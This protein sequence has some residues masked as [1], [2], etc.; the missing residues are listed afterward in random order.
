MPA[1]SLTFEVIFHGPV[2]VGSGRAGRGLDDTVDP[3]IIVPG[4]S[5][6]GLM[7]AEAGLLLGALKHPLI[8]AVFGTPR[9]PSPW[10]WSDIRVSDS[11]AD[12]VRIGAR[13]RVDGSA[14]TA[15]DGGLFLTN[16]HWPDRARFRIAR[17]AALDEAT[18][19][20]HE[21]LLTAAAVSI[22]SMGSDRNRGFGWV[23]VR[24]EGGAPDA[25]YD[26]IA[27]LTGERS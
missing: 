22:R 14:G 27:I 2:K 23:D 16:Y 8:G 11:T 7:R 6:K 9:Q 10:H 21:T 15:V 17:F 12:Q 24:R 26:E 20:R 4:S 19:R 13:I 18:W 25:F 1:T 5:L 3:D